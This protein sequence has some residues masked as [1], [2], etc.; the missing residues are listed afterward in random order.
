M[1]LDLLAAYDVHA[2]NVV[3][4][5]SGGCYD[6]QYKKLFVMEHIGRSHH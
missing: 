6:G 3:S 1:V 5:I 2:A 4:G